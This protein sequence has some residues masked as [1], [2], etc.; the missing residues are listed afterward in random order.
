MSLLS[1]LAARRERK[2]P[3]HR[4]PDCGLLATT[5]KA[6]S[7]HYDADGSCQDPMTARGPSGAPIM[8]GWR[9]P[10]TGEVAWGWPVEGHLINDPPPGGEYY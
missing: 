3:V 5:R 6:L 4:C 1:R 9:Q 2:T 7:L 10:D 8:T